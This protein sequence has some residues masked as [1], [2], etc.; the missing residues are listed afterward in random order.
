MSL[1]EVR[2]AG[3][4]AQTGG[5]ARMSLRDPLAS[6][7]GRVIAAPKRACDETVGKTAAFAAMETKC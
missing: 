4:A 3:V 1:R 6:V 5:C 7:V 2:M